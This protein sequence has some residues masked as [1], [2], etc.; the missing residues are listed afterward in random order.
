MSLLLA[1]WPQTAFWSLGPPA[2]GTARPGSHHLCPHAFDRFCSCSWV[3]C[4]LLQG[5]QDGALRPMSTKHFL[6]P[7]H[8]SPLSGSL[9]STGR[10][11]LKRLREAWPLHRSPRG[12]GGVGVARPRLRPAS[13]AEACGCLSSPPAPTC[14]F[15]FGGVWEGRFSVLFKRQ[16][17]RGA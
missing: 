10:G 12:Q 4:L 1:S 2:R 3:F 6:K 16:K 17:A 11:G 15:F 9:N 5:C 8:R 14:D 13:G 7:C